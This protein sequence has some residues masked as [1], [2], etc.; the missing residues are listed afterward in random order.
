MSLGLSNSKLQ[1]FEWFKE[2]KSIEDLWETEDSLTGLFEGLKHYGI[3]RNYEISKE[4]KDEKI[5][6]KLRVYVRITERFNEEI[7]FIEEALF[8]D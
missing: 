8:A 5:L 2:Y 6:L 4:A 7:P 1:K 3:I